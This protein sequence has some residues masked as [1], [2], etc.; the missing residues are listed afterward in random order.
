MSAARRFEPTPVR[1]VSL[2]H[3]EGVL[4]LVGLVGLSFGDR[5]I[6]EALAPVGTLTGALAAGTA[7]GA[8]IVALLWALR[9]LA[10]L[11]R[12][13]RWQRV[14]VEGWTA[15]DAVSVAVISG[16]AEEVLLRALLQPILGL[17]PVAILFAALH[18]VPDRELWFWP[19]FA[20][21]TGVAL[22]LLYDGLGFPA[23]AAAHVLINL[24]ALLRLRRPAR[25]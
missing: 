18:L 1:A 8:A 15:T 13:E 16:L 23:P 20:L 21:A 2:V 7:A 12:L 6:G 17:A 3:Q 19:V 24:V 25:E 9:R 22:G 10:P 5:G 4:A 11:R 14:V